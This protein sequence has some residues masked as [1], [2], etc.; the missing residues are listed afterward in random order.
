MNLK[1]D[2]EPDD[3]QKRTVNWIKQGEH[4]MVI[5]QTSSVGEK[6]AIEL[7]GSHWMK[8]IF[9]SP[10]NGLINQKYDD[11]RKLFSHVC[12]VTGTFRPSRRRTSVRNDVGDHRLDS[13]QRCARRM[14]RIS[15]LRH[16]AVTFFSL[17]LLAIVRVATSTF[18]PSSHVISLCFYV[19]FR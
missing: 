13:V 7:A 6:N 14:N 4:G 17:T 12:N 1:F 11:F 9:T 10:I 3:F 16:R 2:F 15:V 8:E 18:T 5:A 19:S